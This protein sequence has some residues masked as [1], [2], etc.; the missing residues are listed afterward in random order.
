MLIH[1]P[2]DFGQNG[3]KKERQ[4]E[5]LA[6]EAWA[7]SGKVRQIFP[8]FLPFFHHVLLIVNMNHIITYIYMC[9]YTAINRKKDVEIIQFTCCF[10]MG[11]A[12]AIGVS[13][14]CRRQLDDV[15]EAGFLC[16]S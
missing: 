12:R 1:F 6:L 7:K 10:R 5:W 11:E 3:S 9:V 4:A 15:L 8:P 13:H 2:A 16:M 14:Y